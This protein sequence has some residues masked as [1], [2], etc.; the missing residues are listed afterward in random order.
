MQSKYDAMQIPLERA[1]TRVRNAARLVVAA[2]PPRSEDAANAYAELLHN[3]EKN[4]QIADPPYDGCVCPA[5][6]FSHH[7][8][9]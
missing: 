2:R 8:T 9:G 3:C 4:F 5:P 1:P 7:V 6:A